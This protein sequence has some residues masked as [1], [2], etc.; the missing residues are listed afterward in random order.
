MKRPLQPLK[1]SDNHRF[2]VLADGTPFFWLGDTVWELFHKLTRE[3][4]E[5]YLKIR[6]G[7]GFTVIQAVAL[8]EFDGLKVSN[9]YDRSP[10][11]MNEEGLFDPDLPDVA[12]P[13][14]YW[15][16]V[17]AIID[18]AAEHGIYCALLPTW[19]D[20]YNMSTWGKGP[21]IFT[22]E[23]AFRY[24]RWIADRYR[25]RSNIIWVLGG[26][27]PLETHR[28]FGVI[29]EMARGVRAGDGGAHLITFHPTGNRSSSYHNHDEAWLDFNMIQSGHGALN[30]KNYEFVENDYARLPVKP[31]LDGEPR[32][33]DHP[34]NFNPDNGYYDDFDVRQAAY[35]AVFAGAFGHTYGHHSVWSMCTEP[36]AYIIMKWQTALV[37]PGATHMQHLRRLI[38]SKPFL[39]RIPD[40]SLVAVQY[41]GA[42]HL[43]ATRGENYAMIYSPCG[44]L[45]QVA[46]GRIAGRQVQASWFDPRTGVKTAIGE[47]DNTGVASF[48]PPGSG[49][50]N[51]WV[52]LLETVN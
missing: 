19:G 25:D 51:D 21:E 18:L 10:L 6:A 12:G 20:K 52:L 24:G 46:M 22:P 49:R 35:W 45:V 3:E 7:Q 11:L 40:Q 32:Y 38:E 27:R 33:E 13:Y 34:I 17:D 47:F 14:S 23:N 43:Q 39:E 44:L 8:S 50:N 48:M 42:N 26:D 28:H 9:A 31:T 41:G 15:D 30:A 16:H 36:A 1:V 2:L 4:A 37:R 5:T 29:S